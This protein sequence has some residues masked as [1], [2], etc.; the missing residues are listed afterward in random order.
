MNHDLLLRSTRRWLL[1]FMLALFFS[2]VTA[3]PVGA[4]L[5]WLL[6]IL[7]GNNV[8]SGWL[9]RVLSAWT[10][11][12]TDYPFLLY[13]Y[14]WLAFAHFLLALLFIGPW[15]DP[16]KNIWVIEFGMLASILVL[17]LAWIAGPLRGIPVGWRLID[18]SFG[19][20]A[21]PLLWKCRRNARLLDG[22][23]KKVLSEVYRLQ[24]TV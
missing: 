10:A 7:P 1:F 22:M 5:K 17:P 21:F 9:Q 18:C 14:D 8:F 16:V 13:G 24:T 15:K 3:I 12:A 19:V 11:V 4:E 6:S 2:G 23:E 20:L